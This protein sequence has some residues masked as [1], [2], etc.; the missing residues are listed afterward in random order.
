MQRFGRLGAIASALLLIAATAH[1]DPFTLDPGRKAAAADGTVAR[2]ACN[3]FTGS[4]LPAAAKREWV[5]EVEAHLSGATDGVPPG[6][7]D[8]EAG[9]HP[10]FGGGGEYDTQS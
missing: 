8:P 4:F 1:A 3:S 10:S 2:L 5:R 7:P 9:R 6:G